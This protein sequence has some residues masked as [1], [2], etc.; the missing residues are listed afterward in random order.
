MN[1]TRPLR[2]IRHMAGA[3]ATLTAALLV[4]VTVAPAAFADP[5]PPLEGRTGPTLAPPEVHT[6]VVGGMP[7]WQIA[8]IAAGAAVLAAVLAVL[9]ARTLAAR[10]HPTAPAAEPPTAS[11]VPAAPTRSAAADASL[12]YHPAGIRVADTWRRLPSQ[13]VAPP[14]RPVRTH[15]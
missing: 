13:R 6:I 5:I 11:A 2:P 7:V 1:R 3:L 14:T 9:A 8:L 12:R 15:P 4:A 10:R